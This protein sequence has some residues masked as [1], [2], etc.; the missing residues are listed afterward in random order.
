VDLHRFRRL[1]VAARRPAC[2]DQERAELFEEALDL[3]VGEPLAGVPGQWAARMRRSWALE[4]LDV[5]V[6]WAGAALRIGQHTRAVPVL[7]DLTEAHPLSEPLA[8]ALVRALAADSR[9]SEAVEECAAISTRLVVE[10]GTEPGPE[11]RAVQQALLHNRPLPAPTALPA[12]ATNPPVVRAQLPADVRGFA[13]RADHLARL[14]ALLD[15]AAAG[16]PPTVVISAVSGTAGVGKTALAVHWAHRVAHRFPDGLLYV[17]LRGFDP[18]GQTMDPAVAVRGFLDAL[19]VPPERIP[20]SPH[21]QAALYRGL[22][23]GKRVLVLLDNARDAEQVRPLLPGTPTALAVVTS[24]NQL[25]PLVAADGAHPLTL[26][27][28]P[29]DEARELVLRRLGAARV[30]AEPQAVQE[31]IAGC[32]RLPL[33]LTI[34]AARAA[35]HPDFPLTAIAAEL[36]EAGDRLDALDAGNPA[37]RVRAV[38]SW[39]YTALTPPAARLFRL[40][41]LHPGPD[42]S[43]AAAASLAGHPLPQARTLLAELTRASLLTEHTPGRYTFHDL[44]R[45]YATD[46]THS[47]DPDDQRRA[48]TGRLLDHYLHTAHAADRLL[49]PHADPPTLPLAPPTPGTTPEHLADHGQAMAW[50]TAERSTLLAAAAHA[51]SGGFDTQTWQLAW[52]L[53]TFLYRRGHWH[54]LAAAWQAALDAARRLGDQPAQAQAHRLLTWADIR[55]GRHQDTHTHL[56]C[57][58]DLYAQA[59]DRL[60]QA[61]THLDLGSMWE[62]QGR[63]DEA[64]GH[65][66]QAL[67]LFL[68]ADHRLGQARALNVAGW[69]HA[70]LGDHTR[71]LDDC[72]QALALFQQL[73]DRDGEAATWDSLGYAHH[74]LDHHS[75][76]ADCYQHA[77]GMFR[78]LGDRHEE[79][80]TLNRLGDTYHAARDAAGARIAWQHAVEILTD[81]DHPDADAVRTKLDDVDRHLTQLTNLARSEPLR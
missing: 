54:D 9:T 55:L 56:R 51:S 52:A 77:I 43:A 40:L 53:D 45:A 15:G 76:A 10:L 58:L 72:G 18:G 59:G 73:G 4:R 34:A 62:R 26:D 57:A 23:A 19:A 35:T 5:T 16:A 68:D 12:L 47:H 14:D 50:L 74:R 80:D 30:A 7:R 39:S 2:P 38:F 63:P 36:V 60:G 20:S 25:T 13:G 31:I 28:L 27:V 24:R 75:Q 79:A 70:L 78:D 37:T 8:A 17:N 81:L 1:A 61:H 69:F 29:P 49:D 22:L 32:A 6:S 33:A 71:A 11:L 44:L 66:Q 42:T 64:L 65:A 21:A 3:W 67:E 48:A 41:G 46:L